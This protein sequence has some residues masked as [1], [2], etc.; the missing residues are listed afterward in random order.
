MRRIDFIPK[1]QELKVIQDDDMFLINSDTMVLGEFIDIKHKDSVCDFGTN[2][3]AL[4][5]YASLFKP[6]KM[7]GID[8]NK[9]ALELARENMELNN[10]SNV[11][12][13]EAN[14]IDYKSDELYDVIIC[15]PPYFKTKEDNMA[16]NNYLNLAKHEQSL[17]IDKLVKS[18]SRNLRDSGTLYFLHIS[19][20]LDEVLEELKKNNLI[21]KK[22]Q[23]VY[24]KNKENSNVFM[25][26]CVKNANLGLNVIKPIILDRNN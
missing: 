9:K 11:E 13:K 6:K 15:N 10:I 26:K 22:I 12:L 3:G 24:D 20:R 17:T 18:I 2:Q 19:P 16:D 25:V 7:T 1:H 23:F 4:L 21:P 8:I 14:I 5:L